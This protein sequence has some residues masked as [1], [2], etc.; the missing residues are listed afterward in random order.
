MDKKKEKLDKIPKEK[1]DKTTLP[2]VKELQKR[3][4]VDEMQESYLDYAMSVIV[5]R[6]LPDVRDGLKPVH[7]RILYVMHEA[8][9][10]S[11]AKFRKSAAVV[12]DVLGKYH[13]HGDTAVYDSMVRMAQ[14]FSLRYPLVNGQGNWGSLDGDNAAAYRY[15]EAKMEKIAE[16]MIA[17]IEKETVDFRPNYDGTR[18]EP[19]V[20]PSKIPQLL[21]NGS[22]GIAVGMATSI[23]PHNL[24]E[25]VDGLIHLVDNPEATIEKLMEFIK[26]PDFPTG[27]ML[28]NIEDIKN[29]YVNGRGGMVIRAK[30]VIEE[31]KNGK[32]QIIITEIPYQ[33]NKAALVEQIAELV[34]D[35]KILGISDLRDESNRD[36][37][38]VVIELKK[39]GY[40]KKILNQLYKHTA[41][42]TSFN[43]NMIALVDNGL[44]PRLLDLKQC[45]EFFLEHRQE[46]V[47]NRTKYELKITKARVHILEGL[48]IALDH[49]DAVIATIKKSKTRD[50]AHDALMKKF[51]LSSL[52]ADAILEMRLQTLAGLE[53]QKILDELKEKL[54][55]I[56]YLESLLKDKKK[57][58]KII[59]E[60]L[61][62]MKEKF[63]D[64][65]RTE[66]I[67]EEL[68]KFSAKDTIPNEPAIVTLTRE[69]YIKRMAPSVFRVQSRGG[70]GVRLATKEEDEIEKIL[71]VKTHDNLLYFSNFGRV[72]QLPVHEIPVASRQAKGQAIVN[73]LQLKAG[74]RVTAILNA[75]EKFIGEALVMA[76]T[77]GVIKKTLCQAFENVRKSGLIAI[78]L[79]QD[80]ALEWV[81]QASPGNEIVIITRNGKC[82][83]FNEKDVRDMGRASQGVRGIRLKEGDE[84]VEMDTVKNPEEDELFVIM[85]N[86]LG[87][88]TTITNYRQQ[89]RGGSGVKTA[90]ITAKTGKIVGAR[91]FQ[92]DIQGDLILISKHGQIIRLNLKG[93][94]SQ[95]RATQ[96]V[97]LMRV[98]G[99][100]RV[101]SISVIRKDLQAI[102]ETQKEETKGEQLQLA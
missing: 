7:R 33:V 19:V 16:E 32:F 94:P 12:G 47:T 95:G 62:E 57:V 6:A 96:G 80:D 21:L 73:L 20:F 41:M 1:V 3:P 14:D 42:Q 75:S 48:K 50:D 66:I 9:L 43:M 35:K 29:A 24:G 77:K 72:F 79:R 88:R 99:D 63:A 85:E 49:I 46:V 65:R 52:Q 67:P 100:D 82:I 4:I 92:K 31:L 28:Y 87:K 81:K 37:I 89:A 60:E 90:N 39:D 83:R 78:K 45:L 5:S 23:P 15:T 86:G 17:D 18:E 2:F 13:P 97:Y 10:G 44:V 27:A 51:K 25:L 53:Q 11:S 36:G 68:G 84:V 59:K 56:D 54:D 71:H 74:E 101:A 30:A 55:Y 58:M 38:R 8:G 102:E 69:N 22:V 40:P 61:A 98:K 64:P 70:L 91:V 26:G 76:T 34:R 93:V